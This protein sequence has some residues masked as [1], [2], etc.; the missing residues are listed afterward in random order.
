MNVT[1]FK[2][3]QSSLPPLLLVIL[4]P[5]AYLVTLAPGLTWANDGSDGGDLISAAATGGI[6]HP[7]GYPL[8]LLLA[9]IFQL[10]PLGSLAFRT[11]LMSAVAAVLAS[12]LIYQI[13]TRS[14][15]RSSRMPGSRWLSGLAAAFAFGLAPLVWSQA[16]ITEVYT[17]QACLTAWVLYLYARGHP[18]SDAERK[19]L[20]GWR[21]FAL[22]LAICNQVTAVLFLPVA[23]VLGSFGERSEADRGSEPGAG[24]F[25]HFRFDH[26]AL[27]RQLLFLGLGL[28]V[29]LLIPLRALSNPPVNWGNAVTPARLWWLVSGGQYQSYYLQFSAAGVWERLQAF[30][31]LMIQQFGLVGLVLGVVGLVL[32]GKRS[33][34]YI[35][36]AWIALV[37]LVF[38]ILYGSKDSYL[39]L[40][41]LLVSF[42]IW[43]GFAV[44]EFAGTLHS[45]RPIWGLALGLI[46]IGYFVIRPITY[47]AEVDASGD[48]QAEMFGK[49]VLA[50]APENSILFAKG[51]R[52]VFALWY[53][54]YA[55][56][57]RSDL[58][59]LAEDLLH[60]DWY[61]ETIHATYPALVVP[62][63]FPW[64]ETL[65][66]ANASR[67]VCYVRY[68]DGVD[69]TCQQPAAS[70]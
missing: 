56:G 34:L 11:N 5:G 4:L 12:L 21:G 52:A 9:R 58:A 69:M 14:Q 38:A 26:A 64:P 59:V 23:L 7:T 63:P 46:V 22:G 47:L 51:D 49:E 39:Y 41:P 30:A 10:L 20:D 19:R 29:Y 66:A 44:T 42:A 2:S 8:Y 67:P 45:R 43:I 50:A 31:G 15:R 17:L 55:L 65:A 48:Q 60:F 33:R 61:Q 27:R 37:S 54:H 28:S 1:R 25:H 35:L 18:S 62:G 32:F 40:I 70:P 68:S 13:V 53:F 36:T 3:L 16:V 24:L 6:A 57:K